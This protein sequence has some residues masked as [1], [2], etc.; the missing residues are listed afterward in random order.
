VTA[1]RAVRAAYGAALLARPRTVLRPLGARRE[2]T[3]VAARVLGARHLL[4]ALALGRHHEL[5]AA[6]DALHALSMLGFTAAGRGDGLAAPA[7]AVAACAL[8]AAELRGR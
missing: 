8:G 4:E 3:V 5:C 2:S 6:G 1:L 7:S